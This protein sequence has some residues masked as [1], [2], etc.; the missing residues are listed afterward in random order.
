MVAYGTGSKDGEEKSSGGFR[1]KL[2]EESYVN[3]SGSNNVEEEI[4]Q[5]F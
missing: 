5:K 4:L 2:V 1:V 3:S